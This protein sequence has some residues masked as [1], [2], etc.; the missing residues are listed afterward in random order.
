M[1][2]FEA[3]NH[4]PK[5]AG[6]HADIFYGSPMALVGLFVEVVR[7]RY[8]AD[9]AEALPW[10]WKDDP[11]PDVD[12]DNQPTVNGGVPR[13]LYIESAFVDDPEARNYRPAI[14][15]DK[16][17]TRLTKPVLGNRSGYVRHD[18]TETFYAPAAIP[19]EIQ[20]ISEKRGESG[21]LGDFTW[22][23]LAACQALIRAE[24]G[25]HDISPPVLG[26]TEPFRRTEGN[27]EAW[28]TPISFD[29]IVE[30]RWKTRPI[31]PLLQ[32]VVSRLRARGDGDVTEG[33]I[34]TAT[35]VSALHRPR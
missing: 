15:V 25:V 1:S 16:G 28:M 35:I 33:A 7:A 8:R 6:Q 23:H 24:S 22:F 11:T 19:I 17:D 21:Q 20:C 14:L 13:T 10:R 5:A 29:I 34:V 32:S 12:E 31:A 9:S 27:K 26:K 4:L 3:E 18:G 30:Y 2:R